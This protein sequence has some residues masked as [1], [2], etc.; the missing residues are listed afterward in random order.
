M[1]NRTE[2]IRE[3][4]HKVAAEFLSREAGRQSLITVTNTTVSDDGKRGT[5]YIT[6][7]PEKAESA[8]L[9]FANRNRRE[10][11][12]FFKKRIRGAFPPRIEFVIDRGEKNRQRLDELS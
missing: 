5:I 9:S 7:L 2:K 11:A 4:L 12:D 8:A 3:A 1:N 6:V 10:L